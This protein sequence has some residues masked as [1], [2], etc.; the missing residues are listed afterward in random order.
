MQTHVLDYLIQAAAKAPEKMAYS[1]G[2]EQ[3]TFKEVYDQSRSVGTFLHRNGIYKEP[4]IIFMEKH[5]KTIAAFYGVI[6]GGNY[7]IPIDVEMPQNRIGLILENVKSKVMICN[8]DTIEHAKDFSFDGQ[9]VN[10]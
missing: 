3:L 7:Y 8:D 2:K 5:P 4:V 10:L 9:I 1:N 6:A